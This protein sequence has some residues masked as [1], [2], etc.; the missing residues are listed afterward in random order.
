LKLS[1]RTTFLQ[2]F[3]LNLATSSTAEVCFLYFVLTFTG[4]INHSIFWT[5]LAPIKKG[6]G[7]PPK[8]A[9]LQAIQKEFG[10]LD[11]F[12]A[13]F[14]AQT[15]AVQGSGW[16]WLGYNKA[17]KRLEISSTANQDPLVTKGNL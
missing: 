2:L 13:K 6:G 10:T 3:P 7:D 4:H 12:I 11:S 8:G 9:L 14:N 5:N 17:Y 15:A 1:K 16:G